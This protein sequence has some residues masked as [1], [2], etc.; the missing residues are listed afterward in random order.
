[1]G[2]THKQAPFFWRLM[3]RMT[4]FVRRN[5]Q[6]RPKLGNRILFLTTT[7]R[8]SGLPRVTPLQYE[9]VDGDIYLASARG[10]QAD[11]VRNIQAEA[12]VE[13]EFKDMKFP[14]QAEVIL[15]GQRITQ[16]L[17]IRLERHPFMI[18][19]MLLTHG[20]PP[21]SDRDRLAKLAE[22]LALVVVRRSQG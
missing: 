5:Y 21:W 16:F 4:P 10:A 9:L 19:G 17:E 6:L 13:V 20:L 3:R 8:V 15:D 14:A 1:M 12:N 18:R 2:Q 22:D 11:W 7:G